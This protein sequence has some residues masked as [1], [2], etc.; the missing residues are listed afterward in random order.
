MGILTPEIQEFVRTQ[1]L[2]FVATVCQDGSPN[3]SPKGTTTIWDDEHLVFADI[4]SPGTINNLFTNP[5]IE[6]NI[7]D[8]F[9]RKGYRFKGKGK[10]LTEGAL[11][12]EIISFYRRSGANYLIKNIVLIKIDKVLALSSPIY[13][14]GISEDEVVKRWNS[15]WNSIHSLK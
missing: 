10:V 5:S 6:I 4:R 1:K 11:F 2:G 12:D 3:L 9:T 15:Y 14:T 7:V 13:D 8:I